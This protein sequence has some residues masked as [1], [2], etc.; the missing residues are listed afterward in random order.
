MPQNDAGFGVE[1]GGYALL[2]F[3]PVMKKLSKPLCLKNRIITKYTAVTC[4]V[5]SKVVE[6]QGRISHGRRKGKE[7]YALFEG[8]ALDIVSL[9]VTVH[10]GFSMPVTPRGPCLSRLLCCLRC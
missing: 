7:S 1:K 3:E 5:S 2:F 10:Q 4:M 9:G 8:G 6:A